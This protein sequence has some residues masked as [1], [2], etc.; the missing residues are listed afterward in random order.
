MSGRGGRGRARGGGGEGEEEEIRYVIDPVC[1]TPSPV[2]KHT[3]IEVSTIGDKFIH[4]VIHLKD[5]VD[6]SPFCRTYHPYH[7]LPLEENSEY[8]PLPSHS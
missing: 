2:H 5:S 8:T 1:T 4:V 3:Y 6:I 7:P